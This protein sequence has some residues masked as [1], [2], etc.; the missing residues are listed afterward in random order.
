M[1]IFRLYREIG[2]QLRVGLGERLLK[3]FVT[4]RTRLATLQHLQQVDLE[5]ES[6]IRWNNPTRAA[7]AVREIW[8]QV[9]LPLLSLHH[10]LEGLGPSLD[11]LV[12]CECGGVAAIHGAVED[13]S[14]CQGAVV[15]H[16]ARV[17]HVRRFRGSRVYHLLQ[18]LEAHAAGQLVHAWL[19]VQAC[20]ECLVGGVHLLYAMRREGERERDRDGDGYVV[21]A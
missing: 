13:L 1:F 20:H 2:L 4:V 15:V 10:V 17:R 12:R 16:R 3:F 7:R 14:T 9:H 8:R 5:N 21:W 6:R 19:C 11:H 18:D